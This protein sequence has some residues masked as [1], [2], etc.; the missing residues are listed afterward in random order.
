MPPLPGKRESVESSGF[1]RGF[2][3]GASGASPPGSLGPGGFGGASGMAS[4]RTR[5][6][7]EPNTQKPTATL[8]GMGRV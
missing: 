2:P 7:E 3:P 5:E 4:G 1:L 6:A 8:L